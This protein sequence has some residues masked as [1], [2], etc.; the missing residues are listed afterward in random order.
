MP[1]LLEESAVLSCSDM[2]KLGDKYYS[3]LAFINM[4]KDVL[5]LK[6]RIALER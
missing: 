2:G 4:L 1:F 3:L 5:K 6:C